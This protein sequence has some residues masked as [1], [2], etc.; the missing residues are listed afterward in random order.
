[1]S[2]P[3]PDASTPRSRRH[4][5]RPPALDPRV[6]HHPAVVRHAEERAKNSQLRLADKITAVAGSM[7]F[8]YLHALFFALWMLVFE[9]NPWPTLTLTVSLEA[10]FLST[11]VLI[12]QNRQA[13]FQ[14]AKADHDYQDI[15]T[16]LVEN[17]ALTRS[18][19]D[20]TGD[21]RDRL[22]EA[23]TTTGQRDDRERGPTTA[24]TPPGRSSP[25]PPLPPR[26]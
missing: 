8:V 21:V 11:F 26:S 17:T 2:D 9:D 14:Q 19:Q 23:A 1:M 4:L 24:G 3:E 5:T 6:V 20:L 16:L 13:A 25:T 12:S 15:N 10:I 22:T 18:I 7:T